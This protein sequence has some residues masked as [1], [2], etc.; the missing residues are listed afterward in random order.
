VEIVPS[1]V[2]ERS[3]CQAI[4]VFGG[5]SE[6]SNFGSESRV[7][8]NVLGLEITME[9]RRLRCM[10]KPQALSD[11]ADNLHDDLSTCIQG[12][13]PQKIISVVETN[14]N[15]TRLVKQ[16]EIIVSVQLCDLTYSDP[17]SMCSMTIICSIPVM[18]AP[19]I[20]VMPVVILPTKE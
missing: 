6:V 14:R 20:V 4:L 16:I 1:N 11:V 15:E 2:P 7:D 5:Q 12:F 8:Q 10:E 13:I 19:M 18:T 9:N 17:L 3:T